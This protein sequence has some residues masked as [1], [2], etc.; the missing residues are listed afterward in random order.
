MSPGSPAPPNAVLM[1]MDDCAVYAALPMTSGGYY[2][3]AFPLHEAGLT[4]ALS[5]LRSRPRQT[6]LRPEREAPKSNFTPAQQALAGAIL[7]KLGIG[8]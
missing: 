6:H 7:A 3:M 1:W 2:H 4:K 5:L 8:G